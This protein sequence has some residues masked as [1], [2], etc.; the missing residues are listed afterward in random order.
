MRI[1]LKNAYLLDNSFNMSISDILIED[2]R[3]AAIGSGVKT[4]DEIID[5]SGCTLLPGFVNTNIQMQPQEDPHRYYNAYLSTGVMT[6]RVSAEEWVCRPDTPDMFPQILYSREIHH[7]DE[8]LY[9][10]FP[11]FKAQGIGGITMPEKVV[12]AYK[13]EVF[14]MACSR[15]VRHGLWIATAASDPETLQTMISCGITELLEVPAFRIPDEQIIQMVAK[16]I[17]M[18]YSAINA[19]SSN[20]NISSNMVRFHE[21]GGLLT[22]SSG[23]GGVMSP[24]KQIIRLVKSGIDLQNAVRIASLGGAMLLGTV[25]QEGA[26]LVGKY[27]NLVVI[28]GNPAEDLAALQS[29]KFVMRKGVVLP[30]GYK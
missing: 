6:I 19:A 26:I 7:A 25:E 12:R 23:A 29:L 13:P 9:L 18:S 17:C 8:A 20:P 15:A 28:R 22:L 27:A 1:L 30:D 10:Q 4:A 3:I 11:R 16:G 24:A 5:L 21:A 2:E 14:R